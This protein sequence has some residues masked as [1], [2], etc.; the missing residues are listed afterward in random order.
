MPN[1]TL[2][3][4]IGLPFSGKSTLAREY[5]AAGWK[6]IRRDDLLETITHSAEYKKDEAELRGWI[7]DQKEL[8][9]ARSDL[10]TRLLNEA[11]GRIVRENPAT[12]F[13]YDGTNLQ[14]KT[15]EGILALRDDGVRVE[16][17]YLRT[18][19][20]EILKRE[21]MAYNSKERAGSFNRKA[22]RPENLILMMHLLEE[23]SANEGFASL[24]IRDGKEKIELREASRPSVR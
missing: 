22:H 23:P 16:G 21:Q 11:V 3:M 19:I 18:T 14:R 10:A 8:F 1:K 24:E 12:N 17:L 5:E 13:F 7:T 4:T 6:V 9:E 20:E 2:L 15:R